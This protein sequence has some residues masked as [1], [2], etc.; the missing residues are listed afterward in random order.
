M[1]LKKLHTKDYSELVD[2]A[3][4]EDIGS[5]DI[6]TQAVN[7]PE[8]YFMGVF[9]SREEGVLAGGEILPYI[10]KKIS[11]ESKIKLLLKDGSKLK[12]GTKIAIIK[13]PTSGVLRAERIILNF[14][15]RLCGIAT[16]T[17]QFVAKVEDTKCQILDTRK[18][19]PG[20]RM[21]EKYA[22]TCGG[23]VNHRIGLFDAVMIKDNHIA[24]LSKTTNTPIREGVARARA[25]VGKSIKITVEV[26]TLNQLVE[27]L[28]ISPDII[29]LDN[30]DL[31][32]LKKAVQLRN[33]TMPHIL[34]EASGGVNLKTVQKI[35][36]TGVDRISIG[37]LTHS[38]KALDI[39]LDC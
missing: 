31:Q 28:S 16:I 22:V 9:S 26:D 7:L 3:I 1:K 20:W 5:G 29:L 39:G 6:T 36:K 15:Q 34:L 32:K 13:G 38:V 17:Q 10:L 12:R 25:T 2:L 35:A 24:S 11:P 14:L 4:A 19:T 8:E 33:K 21:L 30:M 23:G 18:T 27:A 37:A